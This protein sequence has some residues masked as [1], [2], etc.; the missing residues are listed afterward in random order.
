MNRKENIFLQIK[1]MEYPPSLTETPFIGK[2][3]SPA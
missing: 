1:K 2:V 3:S